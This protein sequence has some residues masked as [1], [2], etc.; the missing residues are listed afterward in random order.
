MK[1]LTSNERSRF[2]LIVALFWFAQYVY[3][4]NQTPFLI[5]IGV[6]SQIIGVIMGAYGIS[7]MILRLP[8]G[9]MADM[10][11]KHK[12]F[13]MLGSLF[14]GMA[15]LIRLLNGNGLGFLIA[16]IIS[17][18]AS[19]MWI[20]YMVF[21]IQRHPKNQ[22][23]KATGQIVMFMNI[24]ILT[25]FL[26][27]TLLI[28][29]L[30]MMN[31]CLLSFISG[32]LGFCLSFGLKE[33]KVTKT[34]LRLNQVT[35]VFKLKSL[36]VFSCVALIQQEIQ[37]TTTMSFTNQII[38]DLS[39]S[40]SVVGLSSIIYMISAVAFSGLSTQSYFIEKGPKYWIPIVLACLA[41][42][43]SL[44]PLCTKVSLILFLQI[45]PG[46]ATGILFSY[47]TSEAMKEVPEIAHSTAMG[48]YQA[49]YAIGMSIFPIFTGKLITYYSLVVG[50]GALATI[51]LIG[52]ILVRFYYHKTKK[53]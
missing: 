42:Y 13:I 43:C 40:D 28:K 41:L 25:A 16:N 8:I 21:Y 45:L 34:H 39:Q 9:I 10:M 51:S 11:P 20:S 46:M 5:S 48:F 23:T 15:S 35:S 22:Q 6:S 18:I 53:Y 38:F 4:P 36:W 47:S 2:L 44:V 1:E 30:G 19:A 32:L 3:I 50:Y 24:G 29:R 31:L 52:A 17:G 7:Q 49:F 26:T 37:L 33:A 14:A 27:S 12:L